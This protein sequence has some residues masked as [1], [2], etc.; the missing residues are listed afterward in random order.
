MKWYKRFGL[1]ENPFT[2]DPFKSD[3]TLVNYSQI[4]EDLLYYTASG[5]IVL[6][7]GESGS[8]KT[9][10]LRQIISRFEG[11]GKVV[12]VEGDKLKQDLDVEAVLN[13]KGHGLIG[14]MMKK[15]PNGMILLLDNVSQISARNFEKIKY[16]FDQDYIR[17]VIFTIHDNSD[18]DL[19]PSMVDRIARRHIVIP[20][21]INFDALR[22]VRDRFSDHFFLSDEVI[23]KLFKISEG[24]VRKLLNNCD[25][26]CNFVVK[27]GRGEVLSK[28]VNIAL[29]TKKKKVQ[30]NLAS[31][32]VHPKHAEA[33][34]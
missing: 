27:Q 13:K 14:N 21:L 15:K 31:I 17:S 20:P 12:Y 32:E 16:Y 8:G 30:K 33:E 4:V 23:L 2:T 26:V 9:M 18:I 3:Y 24:N 6:L 19:P 11:Y 1:E 22:I 34:Q 10:M 25:K 28:Y 7:E 29:A 5:S